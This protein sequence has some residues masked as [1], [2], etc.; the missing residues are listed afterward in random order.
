MHHVCAYYARKSLRKTI[1]WY[2]MGLHLKAAK[3]FNAFI[4]I[5]AFLINKLL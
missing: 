1:F 2:D 4:N 5:Q 3:A